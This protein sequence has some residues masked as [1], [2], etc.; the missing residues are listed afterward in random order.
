MLRRY[1]LALALWLCSVTMVFVAFTSAYIV[2]R[3]VPTYDTDT[4]VYSTHWETLHAPGLLL[5]INSVLLVGAALAIEIAR[6]R[7][8]ASEGDQNL[9]R[10][11]FASSLAS[12]ILVL[13]FLAG[14]AMAWN[15]LR[16]NGETM[17]SGAR[18]AFF[19]LLTAAHGLNVALG[20]FALVW[21]ALRGMGW[22]PAK[23]HVATDLTAW[24][25]HAMAVLWIYLLCFL[26]FA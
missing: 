16:R 15:V 14:Q 12:L 6:R 26:W 7:S 24:Y 17:A 23:R 9:R 11:T 1:R 25:V 10:S 4:G 19:Y 13:G 22:S 2:R 20:L 18:P 21:I 5:L 3:G 8:G